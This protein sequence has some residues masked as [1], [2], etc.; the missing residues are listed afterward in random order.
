[1]AP[2]DTVEQHGAVR[3]LLVDRRVQ[4]FA[5][6]VVLFHFSSAALLV[7]AAA[8]VTRR[9]ALFAVVDDPY[10]LMPVQLLEGVAMPETRPG[11]GEAQLRLPS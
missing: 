11:R 3:E 4:V 7:V 2:T 8:E 6:C 9:A 1:M 10:W 5:A